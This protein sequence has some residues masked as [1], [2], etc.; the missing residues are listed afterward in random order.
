MRMRL[1]NMSNNNK[2]D[3]CQ[4][5]IVESQGQENQRK[6]LPESCGKCFEFY[7]YE[8]NAFERFNST[9]IYDI[10]L[11]ETTINYCKIVGSS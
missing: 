9:F 11:G 8:Y 3:C 7:H 5:V 10:C 4:P 2:Q 6:K 1:R